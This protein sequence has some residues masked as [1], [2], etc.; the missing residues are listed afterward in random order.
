MNVWSCKALASMRLH[1]V[2]AEGQAQST[3]VTVTR[4]RLLVD[5]DVFTVLE[6]P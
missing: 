4:S 6:L 1:G 2:L 5:V 3:K